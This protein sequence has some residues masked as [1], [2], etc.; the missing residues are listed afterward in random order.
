MMTRQIDLGPL[1]LPPAGFIVGTTGIR[2]IG[3][4]WWQRPETVAGPGRRIV[5]TK[6]AHGGANLSQRSIYDERY[7]V[8]M[9]DRRSPVRVL[10]AER[11]ALNRAM[12]RAAISHPYRQRISL[13][14]F[15]HGSGRVINDWLE[16]QT[17]RHL[18]ALHDLRVV[19]YDV[20]SVGLRKAQ[21]TLRATGYEPVGPLRWE[22]QA[23]RGYIAGT[24][25]K[26]ESG[27]STSVV[28]V[29][30]CEGQP[31]EV[32]RQLALAANDEEPYMLTT[33]WRSGLGHI[34][35]KVSGGNISGSSASLLRRSVKWSCASP[36]PGD[37]VE[38]QPEWSRRLAIGDT[39]GF[40]VERQGDLVYLTEL[41]QPNFYHVFDTEL[42][43]YMRSITAAGQH[44]WIEGIRYPGEEFTSREAEQ[45]NY[46]LV[47][48]A[49]K[50]KR[51]RVWSTADYRE[52]HTIAAFRSPIGP[53]ISRERAAL[54]PAVDRSPLARV[55]V[56][57]GPLVTP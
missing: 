22:P 37:L 17:R 18:E 36:R 7:S 5:I 57:S 38:M 47:R 6:L 19:A 2:R 39:G 33:S 46:R 8:G 10:T 52:F 35:A 44:W 23:A 26:R 43:D 32:M 3:V 13:F 28:F 20:S 51:G 53:V 1:P 16:G 48:R 29:H 15:S 50:G 21:E 40:P 11:D 42:N 30:G 12:Q 4:R 9:Y 25:C 24:V 34:P 54:A 45:A 55:A 41:G 49:N 31:P 14:D 27:R 56:R